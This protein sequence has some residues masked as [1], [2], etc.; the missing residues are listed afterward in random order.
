MVGEIEPMMM[1]AIVQE[2]ITHRVDAV[3]VSVFCVS[4]IQNVPM[5]LPGQSSSS[6][7]KRE[8][9]NPKQTN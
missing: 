7:Q 8:R 9:D 2:P 5:S 3:V 6:E 4:D 1:T